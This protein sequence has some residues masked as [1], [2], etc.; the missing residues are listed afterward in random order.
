MPA[1]RPRPPNGKAGAVTTLVT[2]PVTRHPLGACACWAASPENCMARASAA[3]AAAVTAG[4]RD[5]T[6]TMDSYDD[7]LTGVKTDL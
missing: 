1:P 4:V 5:F 7:D 3:T 6:M 2:R